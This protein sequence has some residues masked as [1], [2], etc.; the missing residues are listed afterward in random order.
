[1]YE[2]GQSIRDYVNIDDVVDANLLVLEDERAVG[3][4]L[5]VGGGEAVSTRDGRYRHASVRLRAAAVV[6]GSILW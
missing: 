6:T 2:D 1:V 3:H 5:N 4:V